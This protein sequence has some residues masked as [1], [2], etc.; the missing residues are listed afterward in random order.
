MP[1]CDCVAVRTCTQ[2]GNRW[3]P[4][5]PFQ[6]A[7][8]GGGGGGVKRSKTVGFWPHVG[9]PGFGYTTQRSQTKL[10]LRTRPGNRQFWGTATRCE[11]KSFPQFWLR[12][13][14]DSPL[15]LFAHQCN[16]AS[17]PQIGFPGCILAGLLPW[18][19]PKSAFGR[20]E[21]RFRFFPGSKI[22]LGM[23]IYGPEAL[24]RNIE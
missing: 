19:A 14:K 6:R 15:C 20:S 12:L 9:P 11:A 1:R 21:G 13:P 22:R 3:T 24:M 7:D 17:G 2:R 16:S 4:I 5:G 23:P 8:R 10:I 18:K